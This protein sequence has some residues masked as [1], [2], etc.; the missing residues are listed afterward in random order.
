MADTVGL[1]FL[2]GR[3]SSHVEEEHA[4]LGGAEGEVDHRGGHEDAPVRQHCALV[5][6][7]QLLADVRERLPLEHAEDLDAVPLSQVT[8]RYV[9]ITLH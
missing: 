7:V 9:C 6:R 2:P 4:E 8:Q 3:G 5:V 1:V